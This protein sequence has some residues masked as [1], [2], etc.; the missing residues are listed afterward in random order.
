[1]A[2]S[3]L[4]FDMTDPATGDADYRRFKAEAVEPA[5]FLHGVANSDGA[6]FDYIEESSRALGDI[7]QRGTEDG[8]GIRWTLSSRHVADIDRFIGEVVACMF[9][10]FGWKLTEI[11]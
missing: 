7:S 4:I 6:F 9:A 5:A 8:E 3:I 11:A 10:L 2:D 1:M